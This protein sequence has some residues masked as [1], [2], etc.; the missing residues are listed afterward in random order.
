[1]NAHKQLCKVVFLL[2]NNKDIRQSEKGGDLITRTG[3]SYI[4]VF[5]RNAAEPDTVIDQGLKIQKHE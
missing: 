5:V 1:M 2:Y 4:T 3:Y